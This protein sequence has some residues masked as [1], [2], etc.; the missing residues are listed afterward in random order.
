MW[1]IIFKGTDQ[2]LRSLLE[3]GST[4]FSAD[5][6]NVFNLGKL[7]KLNLKNGMRHFEIIPKQ[8]KMTK[9]YIY[10][11]W[12]RLWNFRF[13][14]V[15]VT[16]IY[17]RVTCDFVT[18]VHAGSLNF[19]VIKIRNPP[20]DNVHNCTHPYHMPLLTVYQA[21]IHHESC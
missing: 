19:N 5:R 6:V 2:I 1:P 3:S 12:Y 4:V 11:I 20:S 15:S 16:I 17:S 8:I 10:K 18:S 7:E 21:F 9:I 14:Q 13:P